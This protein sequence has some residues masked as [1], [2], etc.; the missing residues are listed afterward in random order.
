MAEPIGSSTNTYMFLSYTRRIKFAK[1]Y[2]LAQGHDVTT[3][4]DLRV[5]SA[6]VKCQYILLLAANA[7]TQVKSYVLSFS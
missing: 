7:K 1:F 4:S 5:V 3:T 6:R 2:L